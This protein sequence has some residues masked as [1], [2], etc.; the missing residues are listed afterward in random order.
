MARTAVL[1]KEQIMEATFNILNL[2]GIDGITIRSIAKEL[3]KSTAP[4]YTQY[5]N[6]DLIMADLKI[7]TKNLL[8][9]YTQKQYAVDGFL[10]IGVGI[11]DFALQNRKIFSH[12]FLAS[13]EALFQPTLHQDT[14]LIQMKANGL[15]SVLDD[16]ILLQLLDDMWVYTY[17]LATSI[18][19][20]IYKD[21]SLEYFI[22]RLGIMGHNLISYHLYSTGN[23]ENYINKFI[24]KVSQHVS[25][26]EVLKS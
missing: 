15:L 10:N 24:E 13:D 12:Y 23:Y 5:E 21:K 4:I 19:T 2:E 8:L 14:F 22:E 9:S 7:Y 11:I 3:G 26:E 20:G 25:I 6:M 16:A 17:G 18:C 1:N